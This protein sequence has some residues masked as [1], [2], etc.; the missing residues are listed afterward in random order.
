MSPFHAASNQLTSSMSTPKLRR[1]C[2]GATAPKG[3]GKQYFGVYSWKSV[4][5]SGA[6]KGDYLL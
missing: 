3:K 6:G 2:R 1:I 4:D 5:K